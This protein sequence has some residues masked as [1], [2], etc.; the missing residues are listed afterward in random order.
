MRLNSD[1]SFPNTGRNRLRGHKDLITGCVFV[2]QN[3]DSSASPKYLVSSSKDTLLKVSAVK[4]SL[5]I[6][7]AYSHQLISF[8]LTSP[9]YAIDSA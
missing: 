6:V 4:H 1:L 5:L 8:H 7:V 3:N 9:Q 2:R